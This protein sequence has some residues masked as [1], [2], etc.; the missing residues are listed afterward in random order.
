MYSRHSLHRPHL[1]CQICTCRRHLRPLYRPIEIN[2]NCASL[3]LSI[4]IVALIAMVSASSSCRC[5]GSDD[6]N[7]IFAYR[8]ARQSARA[9]DCG[10]NHVGGRSFCAAATDLPSEQGSRKRVFETHNK[11]GLA[12]EPPAPTLAPCWF[13]ARDIFKA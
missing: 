13:C 2:Q 5:S 11:S 6:L 1:Y 8:N 7:N 3:P 10:A 12:L 9:P 4:C